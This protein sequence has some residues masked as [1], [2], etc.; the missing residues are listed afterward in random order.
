[1]TGL[2]LVY[3]GLEASS[4]AWLWALGEGDPGL[5]RWTIALA[6]LLTDMRPVIGF[7][8]RRRAG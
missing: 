6:R 4:G 8:A 1:M 5:G 7:W 3:L 2:V